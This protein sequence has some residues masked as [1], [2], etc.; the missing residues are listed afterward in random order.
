MERKIMRREFADCQKIT[1]NGRKIE[2]KIF[3]L[4]KPY[5]LFWFFR[6]SFGYAYV[7]QIQTSA[8]IR[9][10]SPV[11][12]LWRL[13]IL[14]AP[15]VEQFS[16]RHAVDQSRLRRMISQKDSRQGYSLAGSRMINKVDPDRNGCLATGRALSTKRN[17][18][19]SNENINQLFLL[20]TLD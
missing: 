20:L 16:S 18:D 15:R 14:G 3:H 5:C 2:E 11:S 8:P 4:H 7:K 17:K 6:L 12:G 1:E 19:G 10:I 13:V 9:N